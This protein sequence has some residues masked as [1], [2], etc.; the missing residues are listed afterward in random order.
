[1]SALT[2]SKAFF[3]GSVLGGASVGSY[4]LVFRERGPSPQLEVVDGEKQ[5]QGNPPHASTE[6]NLFKCVKLQLAWA[7]IVDVRQQ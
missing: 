7:I 3:L 1:M 4:L 6:N 2:V 5:L